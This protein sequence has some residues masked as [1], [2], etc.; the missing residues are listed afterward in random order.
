MNESKEWILGFH[1]AIL[2]FWEFL[3]N[4]V[5]SHHAIADLNKV[6]STIAMMFLTF[7]LS[8]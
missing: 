5:S 7:S 1:L 3:L 6:V 8:L 4:L 2:F